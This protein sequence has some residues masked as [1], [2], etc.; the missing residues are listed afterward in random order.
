MRRLLIIL[1]ALFLLPTVYSW[2]TYGSDNINSFTSNYSG[3]AAL[4]EKFSYNLNSN[5][6]FAP[7]VFEGKLFAV[8]DKLTV[9]DKSGNILWQYSTNNINSPVIYNNSIIFSSSQLTAL[10]LD[11]SVKWQ[12]NSTQGFGKNLIVHEGVV[13]EST[14]N[15]VSGYYASNGTRVWTASIKSCNN[16]AVVYNNSLIIACKDK[17]YSINAL[18]GDVEL[19]KSIPDD[20]KS[21]ILLKNDTIYF[22][23]GRYVYAYS[24]ALVKLDRLR[25]LNPG[26][27]VNTNL[28]P[29]TDAYSCASN[30][31]YSF[32]YDGELYFNE[33]YDDYANCDSL[34]SF[35]YDND[36]SKELLFHSGA[37]L[38]V[39]NISGQELARKDF[40]NGYFSAADLDND[41]IELITITGSGVL[42][43]YDTSYPDDGV[44][45][46]L[47]SSGLNVKVFNQGFENS[48]S[49]NLSIYTIDEFISETVNIPAGSENIKTYKISPLEKG[50]FTISAV[51]SD[52]KDINV[53][54]NNMSLTFEA[55]NATGENYFQ[56]LHEGFFYDFNK[57]ISSEIIQ[58][59]VNNDGITEDIIR[60]NEDYYDYFR[61]GEVYYPVGDLEISYNY[62]LNE[63]FDSEPLIINCSIK[64]NAIYPVINASLT[65]LIDNYIINDTSINLMPEETKYAFFNLSGLTAYA[66]VRVYV[67][68]NNLIFETDETNNGIGKLVTVKPTPVHNISLTIDSSMTTLQNKYLIIKAVNNGGFDE[69]LTVTSDSNVLTSSNI[70]SR[71]G[72]SEEFILELDVSEKDY[73]FNIN[74]FNDYLSFSENV[75]LSFTPE[76]QPITYLPEVLEEEQQVQENTPQQVEEVMS[77]NASQS[78]EAVTNIKTSNLTGLV[79]VK[80]SND[81]FDS[82]LYWVLII[83]LLLL[84]SFAVY[85]VSF[86][87]FENQAVFIALSNIIIFA[88]IIYLFK[89]FN[90]HVILLEELILSVFA[91]S[92]TRRKSL[93]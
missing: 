25:F 33:V 67:D 79:V 69:E 52:S 23:I 92:I 50:D 90:I 14:S 48:E 2:T 65:A 74:V 36:G 8:T 16:G 29:L 70:Y 47:T 85:V 10:N 17:L 43:V 13:V 84:S 4:N 30:G 89:P 21:P 57:E 71:A 3:R 5:A 82:T 58:G 93:K 88:C 63:V 26:T 22:T 12:N 55:V 59:D 28:L 44:S 39:I 49:A 76:E 31:L 20:L 73:N 80:S 87:L 27:A 60:T 35:D 41:G 42:K 83:G 7:L 66:D 53:S 40:A 72:E 34:T 6:R 18:T 45:L 37:E 11:G 75:A 54:N 51:I 1:L 64:N 81:L 61:E 56:I 9:F 91:F 77:S 38:I 15:E 62:F 68:Y 78:I 19:S 24:P 86:K 46:Y 32:N